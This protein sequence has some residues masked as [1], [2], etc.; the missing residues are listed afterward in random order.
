MTNKHPKYPNKAF[1]MATLSGAAYSDPEDAQKTFK[2]WGYPN[3]RFIDK[4]GAQCY[5]IW[6]DAHAI[7]IFRGT[8]PKEFSDIKADL[9]AFQSK[10]KSKGDVHSGFQGEIDKVWDDLSF[11]LADLSTRQLHITGHSLGAA[12]ATICASRLVYK[13]RI[14]CLYTF[15]SPRVGDKRFVRNLTNL[16]H[17]RVV[18]NNDIVCKVPFALMGYRHH[19]TLCYI[20]HYGNIR[21]MSWWQRF[22]DQWRGRKSAWKKGETFDGV[23]DHDINAYARKLTDVVLGD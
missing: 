8:E 14:H 21:K 4:D 19:G 10:S 13:F 9:N 15:G 12:M 18:N 22:K 20:N 5:V 23:R 2:K 7:I 11:T 16:M 17:Y 1:L 6:N 3:H